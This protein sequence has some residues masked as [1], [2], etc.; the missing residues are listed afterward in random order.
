MLSTRFR[1]T[2]AATLLGVGA[3]LAGRAIGGPQASVELFSPLGSVERP[4]QVKLRFTTPM[5]PFGDPR[6][7]APVSGACAAGSTG[8]W[9]DAR[10]YA[11]DFPKPLA[12]GRRCVFTLT[13]GL[14]DASGAPI[15]GSKSFSFDTGGPNLRAALPEEDSSTLEED[16]IILLALNARPTPASIAAH[17]SCRIEGVGEV[18]PLDI[19]SDA[20]RD[21]IMAGTKSDYS[22][23]NFLGKAGLRAAEYEG[24]DIGPPSTVIA[25][26]CRRTLPAGGRISIVWGA[27]IASADGL[28]TA[29]GTRKDYRVRPAFAA[30]F[31]CSRTTA[32]ASCSPLEA[33][34]V[35]FTGKVPA[36]QA[37][38]IRLVGPKGAIKPTVFAPHT[39]TV[40]TVEF[41]GPFEERA[42][43]RVELP[44]GLADDAGRVLTNA[45]RFPL[46]TRTGDL[47]P[48][49]KFAGAF[50]I[51]EA[52]EGSVLPVTL[53]A[54][55]A[56][57]A[58]LQVGP[59]KG[60]DLSVEGDAR[61]A[62]WLR[63]LNDAEDATSY[64]EPIAGSKDKSTK[65][66]NTTR[67]T[68][69]I[70]PGAPA[71]AL[72]IPKP[73][74]ARAFEVV[75]IPLRTKGFH[76]VEIAS[77]ILGRALLSKG[78][79]R[80]VASAALVT[81]M[82][83]HFQWGH[84]HS[85]VWVTRLN[86]ASVVAG[87]KINIL[88]S[89]TGDIFWSGVTDASG[90]A[91]VPD[92][93][94]DPATYGG[95]RN[96][97]T[98][99][100]LMVS[101]RTGDDYSFTLTSWSEGIQPGDFQMNT[102][103][104][105][106]KSIW[107]SVF[108]RTLLRAGETVHIKHFV[109]ATDDS[110]LRIPTDLPKKPSLVIRHTGSDQQWE[111]PLAL[112]PDGIGV[113]EWAIPKA[114]ALGEY[115]VSIGE[116]GQA[117]GRHS[118]GSFKV[119][120]FRLPTIRATVRGPG[121]HQI[122]PASVP[123]DL[124]LT[125]LSGGAVGRAPVKLRTQVEPRDVSAADYPNFSF[126]GEPLVAGI[127]PLD[128]GESAP[129]AAPLRASVQPVT[130]AANGGARVTI[131]KLPPVTVPSRLV[132]EMDY[133]DSNGEVA[134]TGTKIDLDPS[135]LH[136]GIASDGWMAKAD[137]LRLKMVVL[138]L[139]DK[140]VKGAKVT[141]ALFSRETYSYRKRLIG[142]F[143]SYD[144]SR[145]TKDLGKT[146][147]GTSDDKGFVTCAIDVGVS[148]EVIALATVRDPAGRISSATK[149]VWLAG[150]DDWYFGGDNGDRMDVVPEAPEYA[151]GANARLQVRM[152]FRTAT[153]L[154][155][156]LRDG[157]VDS[158]VT[159]LSG[160]DPV[161]EVKLKRGYAPN[162]YVSVLA[163]RG[164]VAGWRLWLADLARR[165]DLPWISRDAAS[166]T[167]LIDL[168]KP[169]YRL[170][171][172]KIR[173][174]WDDHRL[175]VKVATDAPTY[176]VRKIAQAAVTVTPP[177]GRAL[178]AGS[179]IAFAAVDEALLQ[180]SDNPS[181]DVLTAMMGERPIFVQTSTAQGQVVGK[182]HYGLKAVAAGGDGGA[183]SGLTRKD[184]Q[185]LLLWQA[186][187]PLDG[188][189]RARIAVPLNDAL[190]GFRLVAVASGGSDLFGMGATTIRTTQPLQIL[191]GIPPLVREG[192]RYVATVLARNATSKPMRVILSGRAGA[193][194]LPVKTVD[195][196]ANDAVTVGWGIVAP[197]NPGE[198]VWNITANAGTASDAVQV[199]QT[200]AAA[201]PVA[202]WQSTLV[203]VSPQI[204]FPVALPVGG[205]P[206]RGGLDVSLARTLGGS[207]PGV[208]A[209]MAQYRYDCIEQ[210]LSRAV[211]LGDRAMW[212]RSAALLPAYLDRDGLVR[213]FPADWIAGDDSLTAYVL[214]L[215]AEVG[216]PLPDDP[217]A[218]MIAGLQSFVAGKTTRSH[219]NV[220]VLD[221][222]SGD[223][224]LAGFGG[225]LATRRLGAVAALAAVK[226]ATPA[227]VEPI[228]LT[229]DAWPTSGVV[230][231]A[232][233]LQTLPGIPDAGTKLTSASNVLR[234]RLDL[235]GT[236]LTIARSDDPWQLLASP[237]STA[238]RLLATVAA[239][240]DW[241][242]DA[243]GLARGLMLK[244]QRGHWDTTV[245]NAVG[246][247]AMRKFSAIFE[248]EPVTGTTQVVVGGEAKAFGWAANPEPATLPW[249]A[250]QT[251]LTLTHLGTGAPWATVTSRAAV[252]LTAPFASG[253]AL[254]RQVFI[255]S[256][257]VEGRWSRGDVMRVKITVTPRAPIEWV[258]IDDPVPAG[259]TILGGSLG[260]RSEMLAG[261]STSGL[262]P[263][264]V[265]RRT[266][267]VHA[268]YESM[269][270][271]TITYEYTLRLNS[272]GNFR[273]P[274]TRVEALYSPE[275]MAMVPNKPVEVAA[276][277]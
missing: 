132:A 114:A 123:L 155:S 125:Y 108:D 199:P 226:S 143:Y 59:V 104:G 85:L 44:A 93:L 187:V 131:D 153:A 128:G 81:D 136:V 204:Q 165:W 4:E 140:P 121:T 234:A 100:P 84:G 28:V 200:V 105:A 261:A 172:A 76:V 203:Q 36:E 39:Q 48:L 134:T 222:S 82:A 151:A 213:F 255:V 227:M 264:F 251:P 169:S 94:P 1:K 154:V 149:S 11:I 70:R 183:S 2:L 43:Y 252:P 195:I 18:V 3:L 56:N 55:E 112:G 191:P 256:R 109:R 268:H 157:V 122:A 63:T 161:V 50:G 62:E 47:P 181:W 273:M 177:K 124:S 146:C 42:A 208:R 253:F 5:V 218:K 75:G 130:L 240:P 224:G 66:I 171:M 215:S 74:G 26:K 236:R 248:S 83:V 211:A 196:A 209:Y 87:A 46:E 197:A 137:D 167:A 90:R 254:T 163:V 21:R 231:W 9:V 41:K 230:D 79:T 111:I 115:E 238:A 20:D 13:A 241:R 168:A 102:G 249:P 266:D 15:A 156:V 69:L 247:L 217:R 179:E 23:S 60:R 126:G 243:G 54:V 38:A 267:A 193:T 159:Q 65:T 88:D 152:P 162:V 207:L 24:E 192:D 205:L 91:Q 7:P 22:M 184:F 6:L 86:D 214:R 58:A 164:R 166:P 178:P 182:R 129:A 277:K 210:Q 101:A 175:A 237:D 96:Y 201:V 239:L 53:R 258:V 144:N 30:R 259:A 71:T 92:K 235:Q 244:Q 250:A 37:G 198:V 99:H 31:E 216:W 17:A 260:G 113:S 212:D 117:D 29:A 245:A 223:I 19:V 25:V 64:E 51:V 138:G 61:V 103:Y 176:G 27:G 12:G 57:I 263:T 106:A 89:C 158:F 150:D 119:D 219:A 80:Y 141:V 206:G 221:K 33:M 145:E 32:A 229:P 49:I 135:G 147:S 133:D 67:S 170:G 77:P 40:D 110:G 274:P 257:A 35:S 189:G 270:K 269:P 194:A 116:I 118:S 72:T 180:L 186:R 232:Y 233:I 220:L 34:R 10:T 14:K 16:A 148:G 139:D 78:G 190:S 97:D 98:T 262:Q 174:G 127:V 225:D 73:G 52:A 272:E 173:V 271:G 185:P 265:E 8:R 107:H 228:A 242:A 202:V 120:E 276:A 246:T 188:Q 68:P 160:K 142:G 45:A 95:C 275:M